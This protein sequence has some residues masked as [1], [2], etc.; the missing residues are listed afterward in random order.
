M[1]ESHVHKYD[2][3]KLGFYMEMWV[4]E[5]LQRSRVLGYT[6]IGVYVY[7]FMLCHL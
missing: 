3:V 5:H 6:S 7:S 2:L 4:S 1:I